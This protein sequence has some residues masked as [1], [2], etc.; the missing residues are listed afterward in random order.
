MLTRASG[1][2]GAG[3][4]SGK[5]VSARLEEFSDLVVGRNSC[6]NVVNWL[7]YN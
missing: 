6:Y 4:T 7:G 5:G 3:R 2:L 1:Q